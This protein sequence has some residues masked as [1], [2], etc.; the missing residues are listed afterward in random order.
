MDNVPCCYCTYE[1]PFRGVSSEHPTGHLLTAV[2]NSGEK[3]LLGK[4]LDKI[5]RFGCFEVAH[6]K[7]T[8]YGIL[9]LSNWEVL[10][11]P[12]I[13]LGQISKENINAT[14]LVSSG[15]IFLNGLIFSLYVRY[16]MSFSVIRYHLLKHC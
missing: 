5:F 7:L 3:Q 11:V 15:C 9:G 13:N 8:L 4:P 16:A 14:R 2:R 6:N 1:V 12:C 10:F